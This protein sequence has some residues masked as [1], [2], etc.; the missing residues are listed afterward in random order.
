MKEDSKLDSRKE[1]SAAYHDLLGS[2]RFGNPTYIDSLATTNLAFAVSQILH[3]DF[4]FI[5]D[6]LSPQDFDTLDKF[7]NRMES[8]AK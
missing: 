1:L 7:L 3:I 8:L 2:D 5:L 6:S 4:Y